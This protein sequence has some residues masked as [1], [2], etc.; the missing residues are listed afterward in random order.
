MDDI[1]IVARPVGPVGRT[2]ALAD[3]LE[4]SRGHVRAYS[5]VDAVLK[6]TQAMWSLD[7]P[8]LA[9]DTKAL[10]GVY[11]VSKSS[12]MNHKTFKPFAAGL[13]LQPVGNVSASQ[14]TPKIRAFYEHPSRSDVIGLPRF[15]GLSV[16]GPPSKD[17]RSLGQPLS[18]QPVIDLRPL[19][20]RAVD[21]TLRTLESWGGANVTADCGFGK[22]RLAVALISRLGRKALILG[23]REVLMLQWANVLKELA[24]AWRLS[25]LQGSDSVTAATVKVGTGP[26]APRFLGAEQPA[27]VCVA[28]IDTLISG[29]MSRAALETFGTVVVDEA[30]HLAARTLVH[31][32]PLV[33][34]RFV[35]GLSATPDRRD[36][37]EHA[38]YWLAGPVSFVYKRLPSVTGEY[39]SVGVRKLEAVGMPVVE[40]MYPNGQ[41]AFAEMITGLT[42]CKERNDLILKALYQALDDGRRKIIVVSALVAHCVALRDAVVLAR[43]E[44]TC[45][46]MAGAHIQGEAAKSADTRMVFATYAL[47]EEGYDDP[48]LD[49]LVLATP[50]SRV[51][52][53]VGR[54]E[55]THDGKLRPLVI[56]VVDMF[57]VFP[58]MWYK[59]RSF[60]ASRGFEML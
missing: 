1:E 56:D 39:G 57:S 60:Y 32:L 29:A 23:N 47:L 26:D 38:L 34:A 24:P 13:L 15:F 12:V 58:N 25:W 46:L 6:N 51:Q 14:W 28:S 30:H 40:K 22:T 20:I 35:V 44:L 11:W 16:F 31:A 17:M 10:G 48:R 49:T 33:P 52:Q 43:P 19:Q 41:L 59:R 36:G 9:S 4:A 7:G 3:L 54:I 21:D 27:D 18:A 2:D 8:K 45:A 37:L 53:T 42:E 50:R 55:R 5:G